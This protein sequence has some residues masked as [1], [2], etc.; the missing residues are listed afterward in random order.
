[1]NTEEKI[2]RAH[3]AQMR[4][5]LLSGALGMLGTLAVVLV[6]VWLLG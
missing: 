6:L 5:A 3:A 1:M 2:N 4:R